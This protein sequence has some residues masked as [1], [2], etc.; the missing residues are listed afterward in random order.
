[1]SKEEYEIPGH[2]WHPTDTPW[3]SEA[4]YYHR[5]TDESFEYCRDFVILRYLMDGD[6]RP[7]AA[8]MTLGRAPG[9]AVLQYL[10]AMFHPAGG[11]EDKVPISLVRKR[12]NGKAGPYPNPENKWRDTLFAEQVKKLLAEGK[13]YEFEAIPTVAEMLP[14]ALKAKQ[15]VR[16]AYDLRNPRGG[17]KSKGD[18]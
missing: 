15:T 6:T 2:S 4:D 13:N 17:S 14:N 8:L 16:D 5:R 10:A 1:M 3:G 11:S 9:P 18:S 12:R 7:L